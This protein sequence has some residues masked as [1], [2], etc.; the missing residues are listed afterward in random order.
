MCVSAEPRLHA[1]LV[2]AAKVTRCIQCSLVSVVSAV[3]LTCDWS[4]FKL[5]LYAIRIVC[6]G[7]QVAKM[8]SSVRS[9]AS[10]LAQHQGY[11]VLFDSCFTMTMVIAN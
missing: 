5:T 2:S 8:D 1:A 4:A 3:D 10:V 11:F 9:S 6:A 7:M